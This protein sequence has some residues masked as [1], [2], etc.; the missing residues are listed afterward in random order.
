MAV[1]LPEVRPP[2]KKLHKRVIFAAL[3]FVERSPLGRFLN[4]ENNK[5]Q[6]NNGASTAP[7][8]GF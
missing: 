8:V 2:K 6:Y 7:V 3:P 5:H 1:W 4:K